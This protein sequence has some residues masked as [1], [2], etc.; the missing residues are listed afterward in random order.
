MTPRAP[1]RV[2]GFLPIEDY[3]AIGDG[4][5]LALVGVDGAIDWLC[6]PQLDSPSMFGALLDPA[7]GGRF[8]V[9]PA[10]PFTSERRYLERTNVLETTFH[11]DRGTVTLTDALTI[12]SSQPAPWRELVRKIEARAGSVPMSWRF[13]PRFD[14]GR[15]M[16]DL[17]RTEDALVG[18]H[19]HLQV[20]LRT[21]DAGDTQLTGGG[22]FGAFTAAEDAGT[23]LAMVAAEEPTLPIPSREQVERRVSDTVQVWRSWVARHTYEGPWRDAVERSLLAIR[24]LADARTGAIAAAGT[25][26]LPE[27]LGGE[28]NYDYRFGWVRDLCFTLDALLS[29]GMDELTSAS[30]QWLL[31][32]TNNSHPR[33]D[34]VYALDGA[35]VRSQ[36][37][38]PLAGYRR[39]APV[40][41]GNNAGA[42]LQLGGFG[43][44]LETIWLYVCHSHL[45]GPTAGER[46][47]DIADL[48]VHI[49]RQEDSGLWELGDTAHYGTSKLGVWVAFDRLLELV[50]RGQV[51]PRHVERWRR[52]RDQ[53]R[54]FIETRLVSSDRNAYLFKAGST[55][56][57]CG[58]LLAARRRFVDPTDPRLSGT[59]DAIGTELRADGPLL[60]RYSGMQD[61]ENAFLACSFWMVEA[62]AITGRLDEAAEMMEGMIGLASDVGLYSEEMEPG[63]RAMRGNFP[64]ALTHLSLI[65]A[66]DAIASRAESTQPHALAQPGHVV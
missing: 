31:Q 56:L 1:N 12:D 44:L 58:L 2:D 21:F 43:D 49:W 37:S 19:G 3:A 7:R 52:A 38:L 29:V 40:H 16:P 24:L 54:D 13:E 26:S 51:P 10:I 15:A 48:L 50:D 25:T 34:P 8:I 45:L 32:A 59:I 28:R 33:V 65:N 35:V 11:T 18:R 6:L 27:I 17:E 47:A 46:L 53:A 41:L 55:E 62:L 23:V 22:A 60:Y 63:T 14:Y 66:A 39:T 42:Q 4:R 9:S 64:Q 61:E 57:D 5:T 30:V 36:Q 20:A